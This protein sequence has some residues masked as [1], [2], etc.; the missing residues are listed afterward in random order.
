MTQSTLVREASA[1]ARKPVG[2]T[3]LKNLH[4]LGY[5]DIVPRSSELSRLVADKCG[6]SLSRQR[7]SAIVNSVNVEDATIELLAKAIGV[8]ADE[9][10]K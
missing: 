5:A 9:L 3:L 2:P 7:I 6:K 1:V 8:D 4:R 10:L